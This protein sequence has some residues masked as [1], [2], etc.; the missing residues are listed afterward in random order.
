MT[1]PLSL[2]WATTTDDGGP[3]LVTAIGNEGV[4]V[5]P[6]GILLSSSSLYA[7]LADDDS[8]SNRRYLVGY[9]LAPK[10]QQSFI[11]SSSHVPSCVASTSPSSTLSAPSTSSFTSSTMTTSVPST[12]P[13]LP[14]IPVVDP[15]HTID[16]LH[17]Y[18]SMLQVVSK[19]DVP[20]HEDHTFGTPSQVVIALSN[21]SLLAALHFALIAKP[22]VTDGT[23]KSHKMSPQAPTPTREFSC[24]SNSKNYTS[25]Q[26]REFL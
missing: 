5:V 25:K 2:S 20:L 7:T 14:S 8:D 26:Y 1:R 17:N 6:L 15:P 23:A 16:C 21:S 22:L 4:S 10:K 13:S 18:I 11:Q 24:C 3:L 19:L 12:T 9:A